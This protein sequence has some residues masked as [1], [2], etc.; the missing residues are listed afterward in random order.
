LIFA[1]FSSLKRPLYLP[2]FSF[3]FQ[4][5]RID[6]SPNVAFIWIL[7]CSEF[8]RTVRPEVCKN[9]DSRPEK[10]DQR[11]ARWGSHYR[12]LGHAVS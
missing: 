12:R 6:P 9:S 3:M 7:W 11:P 2:W 1:L 4:G 10:D 8:W 5:A